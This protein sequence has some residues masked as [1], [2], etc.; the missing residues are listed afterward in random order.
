MR[1]VITCG[2]SYEPVDEVRRLTNFS[3]GELGVLL[4][5]RLTA[6]GHEV[7]CLKGEAATYTGICTAKRLIPFRTND[8]LLQKLQAIAEQGNVGAVLHC[9]A[10]CDF[11]VKRVQNAAGEALTER[12][13]SSRAGDLTLVLEPASK[14]ISRLRPLFPQ[15]Q[16]IGWKFEMD[17]ACDDALTKG[18]QQIRENETDLCVVNGRAFGQG[19]AVSDRQAVVASLASKAALTD[20]L[21]ARLSSK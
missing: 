12:K 10:L 4:A 19:F 2:P 9:A 14:V 15:A 6:D 18:Q 3:T 7:F 8:D 13:V 20:W 21:S 5:N 1:I 11:K 17:G 16:L